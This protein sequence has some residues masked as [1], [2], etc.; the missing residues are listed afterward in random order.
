M[1]LTKLIKRQLTIA[2]V[3][4]IPVRI[5]YR[6]FAVVALSV[7]LIASNLQNHAI[8]VGNVR[9]PPHARL[10]SWILGLITTAGLFLSVFG[11]ELAHAL[12]ARAEGIDIEEIIL[13]PFG[14]LARL[15]TEPQ[16]PRAEFRIAFA[17]PA[18]SFVFGLLAFVGAKV[19]AVGNYESTVIVFFLI[20][21]GNLLLALFNLFPGYPLD[22]GR[23]LRALIWRRTG[24]IKE[25]TRKAGICGILIGGV[26]V[27]FGVY[28]LI[29]PNWKAAQPYFMGA[30]SILVGLFLVDT[31]LKVV[32]SAHKTRLVTVSD[33]MSPPVA[34][35][36]ELSVTKFVDDV[37]PL[38]RQTT[39][40]VAA[41]G[42]L[43][44]ILS[45]EDLKS[46]PRE[47]WPTTLVRT[48][49]RPVSP[50]F[51]V[52]PSTTLDSAQSVMRDNGLGAIAI[53]NAS[54]ELIGFLH[55]GNIKRRSKG[56]SVLT[57]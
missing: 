4:G 28:I 50:G 46:L 26:L 17:G 49:M 5:D 43:H 45:L 32:K 24:N 35:E 22:G 2:R 57:P 55:G 19:A 38:H 47:R 39:F 30:W 25:A 29:S 6:W 14:G 51:F 44:G 13:H 9:L 54:G 41:S 52:E 8:Q 7:W 1:K 21:S 42:R 23:V 56:K 12:M 16:N 18:S 15:K 36:P 48:V 37:L 3:Y 10:T 53:V 27:L 31:A 11:H 33:A 34:L 40:P 20:A